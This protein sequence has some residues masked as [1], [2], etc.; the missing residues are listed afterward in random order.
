MVTDRRT[1][2]MNLQRCSEVWRVWFSHDDPS[3]YNPLILFRICCQ[4]WCLRNFFSIQLT[5]HCD[6]GEEILKVYG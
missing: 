2:Q 1:L 5:W 6:H 4:R 3:P